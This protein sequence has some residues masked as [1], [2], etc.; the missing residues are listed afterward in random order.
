[1]ILLAT[2][3][4]CCSA[5]AGTLALFEPVLGPAPEKRV[6]E[7]AVIDIT[8]IDISRT[9]IQAPVRVV[10]APFEPNVNPRER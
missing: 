1:M 6:A 7:G 9:S 2:V 5:L 3:T 10:G 4:L 8:V